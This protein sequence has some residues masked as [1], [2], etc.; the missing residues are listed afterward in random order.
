MGEETIK[1]LPIKGGICNC[2]ALFQRDY[3]GFEQL[4]VD[5][6]TRKRG[7]G[8]Q[9]IIDTSN[10]ISIPTPWNHLEAGILFSL[11]IPLL[12]FKEDGVEGGVFD[13]GITDVF[14]H[15]M[16]DP[17]PSKSKLDELKQVFLKWYG[18]VNRRYY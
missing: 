8:E 2:Q 12:I 3:S 17:K 9:K 16:P 5:S 14:V 10:P 13:Y 15:N 18:E 6:G 1:R 7:T 4:Y 11:K